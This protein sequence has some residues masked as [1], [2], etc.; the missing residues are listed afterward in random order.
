M[1][2]TTDRIYFLIES[3]RRNG[4]N[5]SEIYGVLNTAWPENSLSKQHIRRLCQEF[6]EG[7]RE[8]FLRLEGQGR[9]KSEVR[10]GNVNAVKQ[11]II[12]DPCITQ[13]RIA[14]NLNISSSMVQRILNDDLDVIWFKTKWVP[15]TLTERNKAVRVEHCQNLKES[16]QSRL[17]KSNLVT[18]DE[19]FFYCRKLK[20]KNKIGSWITAEGDQQVMQTA[21]RSTMEVKYL[22][23]ISVSQR[24]KHFFKIL[25]RNE[26][27]DSDKY[28][29]FLREMI[30]F[31][32]RQQNSILPENMRIQHDNARPH[33]SY[34][35]R[36]FIHDQNIRLLHQPPYSPD[37]NLCDSYIFPRLEALRTDFKSREEIQQ[38]LEETLPTFTPQRMESA[39]LTIVDK[40][41]KIIDAQ[42]AYVH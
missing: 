15:H 30:E 32:Q 42:G 25:Q 38:F 6:R 11:L 20:P 19:K 35:T 4:M 21:I 41:Q 10:L 5:A 26:T 7:G 33:V 29:Q 14:E 17:C 28:M 13:K 1:E 9:H 31:H 39:L 3:L 12:E 2:C 18:I 37:V 34:A 23:I 16:F 8:S 40:M 24:G 36:T 22:V 27:L